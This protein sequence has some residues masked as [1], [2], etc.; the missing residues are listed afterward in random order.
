M[1]DNRVMNPV[2]R[3]WPSLRGR[4]R[5]ASTGGTGIGTITGVGGFASSS[6]Q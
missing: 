4:V 6:E 1:K 5:I 3:F 2:F